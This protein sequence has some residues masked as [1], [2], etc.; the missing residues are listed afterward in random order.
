MLD[1]AFLETVHVDKR[2]RLRELWIP[3]I[4]VMGRL[5]VDICANFNVS[6]GRQR[7]SS[8]LKPVTNVPGVGFYKAQALELALV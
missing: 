1:N 6:G 2:R 5:N 4:R 7:A 8:A 3:G